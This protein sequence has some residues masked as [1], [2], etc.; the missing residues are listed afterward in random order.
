MNIKDRIAQ[1]EAEMRKRIEAEM[2]QEE[3]PMEVDASDH[4]YLSVTPVPSYVDIAKAAYE[5]ARVF[6][7]KKSDTPWDDL[8]EESQK[9]VIE[10]THHILTE[11]NDFEYDYTEREVTKKDM[12]ADEIYLTVIKSFL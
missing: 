10:S 4:E 7:S 3:V 12:L 8:P 11:E 2:K 9:Y 6:K 1:R 5:A